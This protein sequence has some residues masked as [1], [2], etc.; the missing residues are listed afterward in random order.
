MAAATWP[1]VPRAGSLPGASPRPGGYLAGHGSG[2][3]VTAPVACAAIFRHLL[4]MSA[5]PVTPRRPAIRRALTVSAASLAF[6]ATA[7]VVLHLRRLELDP[8]ASQ[9]SLYLIG[10]WGPLLQFAYVA[11]GVGMVA[12]G[13]ALR[14]AHAPAARSA[15]ALL[16]F[17][18]AGTSLS[19][20]A[21]A[22]MDMPGVDRSLEGLIHGVSA[23]GAF[24]FATTGMVVQALGFLRDPHWRRTARWALPWALLCFAS[25]WVLAAWRDAPRG[26]AQKTVIV[27][28]LGWMIC[29]LRSLARDA[30]ALTRRRDC[31]HAPGTTCGGRFRS[32]ATRRRVA[33]TEDVS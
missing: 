31:V 21:Y 3:F 16:L 30:H 11:L 26:L 12:L 17:A 25:V 8:L 20:T 6:F 13:W 2:V 7:A 32:Q 18:L 29:V 1:P 22:W 23:Q 14:E 24:L 10:A 5:Y 28:I 4:P 33:S 19:I 27:L 15:A 9:M